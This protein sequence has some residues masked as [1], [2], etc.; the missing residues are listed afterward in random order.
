M[1][2]IEVLDVC[3][4]EVLD[5]NILHLLQLEDFSVEVLNVSIVHLLHLET[6][7]VEFLDI[8]IVHLLHLVGIRP[9]VAR[10]GR[11]GA[12]CDGRL[13]DAGCRAPA[14]SRAG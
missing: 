12:V 1:N 8:S 2:S 4:V 13:D 6:C 3:S 5:V 11:G 9:H 10:P 7:S 14:S